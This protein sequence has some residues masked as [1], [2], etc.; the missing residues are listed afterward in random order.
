MKLLEL[1]SSHAPNKVFIAIFSGA[2]SGVASALF[3][4]VVMAALTSVANGLS[5]ADGQEYQVFGVDIVHPKFAGLYLLIIFFILLTRTIS[6]VLLTNISLD[7]TTKLR[8]DLY[9]KI[10][11]TNIA[12]LERCS[13]GR[14]I[15]CLTSDVNEI[16]G[17]AG[18]IPDLLVQSAT[19]FGLLGFLYFVSESVFIFALCVI[20]FGAITYQ[21]PVLIG[22]EYFK[23]SRRYMDLL[24]EGFRG[25]VDGAK[26]LKLDKNKREHFMLNQ[27]LLQERHVLSLSKT[28]SYII[29][30]ARN[31][32]DLLN[33]VSMGLIAFV[34]VN[35]HPMTTIEL[36]GVLMV[37]LYIGGPAAAILNIWPE[38][39]RSRVALGR[40]QSLYNDLPSENA[41]DNLEPAPAWKSIQL[42]SVSYQHTSDE[43][44]G[45]AFSIGPLS[46]EIKQGEITF[47]VGGNGSGKSTLAKMISLHYLASSGGIAFDDILVTEENINNYRQQIACIYSDYYLFKQLHSDV[48][49][50][51]SA[52][53]L[54]SQVDFYL[55]VLE[56]K[57]KVELRDGY[58]S[59]LHLS[60]GQRRRL[61][62]LVAFLDNKDL[63]V[64]DEWA[65]DQDP[66]FKKIFYYDILPSLKSQ[67]KAIV[68]ISHDDRYFDVADQILVMENGRFSDNYEPFQKKQSTAEIL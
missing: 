17:G 14:L 61:A 29:I 15:Q 62:L 21:L 48:L 33:F 51:V 22:A 12:S 7:A 35:Y 9:K 18:L 60:D 40:V 24:Q 1:F 5:I 47:I 3:I 41:N 52:P 59:T 42:K 65:A 49:T 28:G 6:H 13:N 4:P 53:E 32:G 30:T 16:V 63:Y 55:E 68:A 23:R 19:L 20:F 31:Y 43:G 50:R 67:G 25:L 38:L 26:E 8:Q 54:Q 10:N 37:C 46:A 2:I 64:F 44:N 57:G 58:F 39:A 45:S 36:T 11:N 34:Y 27:L 56:L 66:E